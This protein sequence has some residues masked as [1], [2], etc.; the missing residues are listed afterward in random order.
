MLWW[1]GTPKQ[2]PGQQVSKAAEVG[3]RPGL[4]WEGGGWRGWSR[5]LGEPSQAHL[6]P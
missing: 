5:A 1:G 4:G 3:K 2:G 6:S